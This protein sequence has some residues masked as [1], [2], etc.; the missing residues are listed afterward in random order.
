MDT[1]TGD[2]SLQSLIVLGSGSDTGAR[3]GL[4]D[5]AVGDARLESLAILGLDSGGWLALAH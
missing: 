3:L 5:L 2:G 4:V 1:A